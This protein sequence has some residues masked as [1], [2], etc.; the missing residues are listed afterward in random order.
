MTEREKEQVE[1]NKLVDARSKK[2]K[3]N[4]VFEDNMWKEN[5]Q[6]VEEEKEA[7]D[8]REDLRCS[9]AGDASKMNNFFKGKEGS[10]GS[11]LDSDDT[12]YEEKLKALKGK[13]KGKKDKKSKKKSEKEESEKEESKTEE[14]PK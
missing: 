12:D 4:L 5:I 3:Q 1:L 10:D 7:L 8:E 6:T 11:T 2:K 13:K 9:M 14:K